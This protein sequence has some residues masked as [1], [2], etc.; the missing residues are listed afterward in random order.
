VAEYRN[1]F[2]QQRRTKIICDE[3]L[4]KKRLVVKRG[5]A[6]REALKLVVEKY[7]VR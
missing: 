3:V 2:L 4:G 1:A 6:I 5:A 7:L